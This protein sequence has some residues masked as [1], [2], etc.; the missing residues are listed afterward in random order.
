MKNGPY[1]LVIA[2][3]EY[4]GMKYRGRYCYEHHLAYWR[5]RKLIPQ[6]GQV[7]HHVN[8]NR[9]DNRPGNLELLEVGEHNA[10]HNTVALIDVP[11]DFCGKTRKLRP[12]DLRWRK[13][14]SKHGTVFCGR[15]CAAKYQWQV[16]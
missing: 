4:P 9:R 14:R 3:E 15:S 6:Q 13:K 1:E 7:L 11:C 10:G 12:G 16:A 8:G 5:E 2:P